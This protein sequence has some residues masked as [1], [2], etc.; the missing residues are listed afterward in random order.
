MRSYA[1]QSAKIVFKN[2]NLNEAVDALLPHIHTLILENGM[3]PM[4]L[5]NFSEP[6]FPQLVSISYNLT[7]D[8]S[9]DLT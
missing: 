5:I 1:S 8:I 4:R 3:D 2:V 7:N 6:I 9:F